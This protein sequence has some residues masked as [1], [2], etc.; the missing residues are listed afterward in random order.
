MCLYP[1]QAGLLPA[2]PQHPPQLVNGQV[3]VE[4][5]ADLLEVEAEVAQGHEAVEPGQLVCRVI[6]VAGRGIHP[7]GAEEADLVVVAKHPRG[8][9]AEPGEVSDG[10]HGVVI[11]DASHCVKV[12]TWPAQTRRA[13]TGVPQ[14]AGRGAR[15]GSTERRE[16]ASP[17]GTAP[18]TLS[19]RSSSPATITV[20]LVRDGLVV[21]AAG[22]MGRAFWAIWYL[23]GCARSADLS[24]SVL[25]PMWRR[26]W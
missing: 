12:K 19:V 5:R 26:T 13:L 24:L 6:A 4:D 1:A 11:H 10:Q 16:A 9:L 15:S 23:L 8:H 17:G 14:R 22:V 20:R 21:L 3:L 18:L 2:H 7:V 25:S